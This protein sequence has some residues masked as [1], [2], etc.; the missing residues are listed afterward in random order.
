MAVR[1][2]TMVG[3]EYE[4]G[5]GYDAWSE[6]RSEYEESDEHDGEDECETGDSCCLLRI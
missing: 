4:S 6:D 3:Y 2:H 1:T 5:V